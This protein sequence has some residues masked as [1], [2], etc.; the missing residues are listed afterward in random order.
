MLQPNI[1]SNP[2]PNSQR[3]IFIDLLRFGAVVCMLQGHTFDALLSESVKHSRYFYF[4]D[5]FHGFVAPMFLFSSGMAFGVS[6]LKKWRE[7]LSFTPVVRKRTKRYLSLLIIGYSLHLPFFSLNRILR[8]GTTS[9]WVTFFQADAL[10]CIAVTLLFLQMLIMVVRTE[11][12]LALTAGILA[13]LIMISSPI[14]WNIAFSRSLPLWFSSYLNAENNS[15]FPLFPW[16]AYLLF[17]VTFAYVFVQAQ[18]NG[19]DFLFMKRVVVTGSAMIVCM[20]FLANAPFSFYGPHDFW[21]VNPAILFARTAVVAM[22]ASGMYFVERLLRRDG[23]FCIPITLPIIMGSESLVIY[24][25][26]LLI[27]YGSA[28][29]DGLES[30]FGGTL[31]IVQ[32]TG[33]FLLMLAAMSALAY[34]WHN[35][36]KNFNRESVWLKLALTTTFLLYFVARPY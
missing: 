35:A 32:A 9:N 21:K 16:S 22:M 25:A 18:K 13:P 17:G 10:H 6:T 26:H 36:K 8:E 23:T 31:S 3:Y 7:H 2:A 1:Q 30:S 19:E 29:N 20:V 11:K 27:I 5:F 14:V 4:H 24:A 34:I 12:R 15:W 33:I 28:V